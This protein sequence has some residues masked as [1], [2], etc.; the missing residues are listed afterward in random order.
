MKPMI[1]RKTV[2]F[3]FSVLLFCFLF[4]VSALAIDTPWVTLRPDSES[5]SE[6]AQTEG[7]EPTVGN[8]ESEIPATGQSEPET[9]P[10]SVG[11]P[12]ADAAPT[13]S[14]PAP[15]PTQKRGCGSTLAGTATLFPV[16]LSVLFI[17]SNVFQKR[18]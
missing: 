2:L 1:L 4:A 18:D 17:G 9:D 11:Q 15:E 10:A 5:T 14:D 12:S 16:L 7:D 3:G 13:A 6:P 8:S